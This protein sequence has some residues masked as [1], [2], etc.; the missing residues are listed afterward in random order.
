MPDDVL[1]V[2]QVASSRLAELAPGTPVRVA[3]QPVPTALAT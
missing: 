2:A 3:L 1:V